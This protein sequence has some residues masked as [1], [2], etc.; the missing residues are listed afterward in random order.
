MKDMEAEVITQRREFQRK[1]ASTSAI[2]SSVGGLNELS[3]IIKYT[4][5][6]IPDQFYCISKTCNQQ[7]SAE[8][9]TGKVIQTRKFK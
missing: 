9:L 5:G 6:N 8:K 4:F 1:T 2:W 7:V 3:V